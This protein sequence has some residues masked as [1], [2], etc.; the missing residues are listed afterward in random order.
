[1]GSPMASADDDDIA[2]QAFELMKDLINITGEKWVSAARFSAMADRWELSEPQARITFLTGVK[3]L[4]RDMPVK[5]FQDADQRQSIISAAQ[6]A[7]DSAIDL[8]EEQE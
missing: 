6:E 2:G 8:E 3:A 4:L 5:V 7:L 1:M